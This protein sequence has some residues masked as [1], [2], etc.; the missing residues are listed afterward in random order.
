MI[1]SGW[2][3]YDNK[4]RVIEKYEPFFSVG[5]DYATPGDAQMGK[6]TTMFY[7]PRGQ[8]MERLGAVRHGAK[9]SNREGVERSS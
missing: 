8:V 2:Q 4:G 5:R 7:D 6:K 1:V 9:A 3:I